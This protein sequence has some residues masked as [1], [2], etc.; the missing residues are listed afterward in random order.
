MAPIQLC[1]ECK[2]Y[3]RSI[4]NRWKSPGFKA[5]LTDE[6]TCKFCAET[7]ELKLKYGDNRT[8]GKIRIINRMINKKVN[9]D[10]PLPDPSMHVPHDITHFGS[11]LSSSSPIRPTAA[12]ELPKVAVKDADDLFTKMA[13]GGKQDDESATT[14]ESRIRDMANKLGVVCD[15]DIIHAAEFKAFFAEYHLNKLTKAA[16]A[17]TK[18]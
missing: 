3:R 17:Y 9:Q 13:A 7:D 16:S 11:R 12:E 1:K 10:R 2:S 5:Y 18:L 4:R 8:S 15:P 14:L 6:P